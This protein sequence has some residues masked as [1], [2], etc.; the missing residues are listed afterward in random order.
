[1]KLNP[2]RV[3]DWLLSVLDPIITG[4][5]WD[6]VRSI[7]EY[8]V[9]RHSTEALENLDDFVG[10]HPRWKKRFKNYDVFAKNT[11]RRNSEMSLA[12]ANDLEREYERL[13]KKYHLKGWR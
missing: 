2:L 5:R 8:V 13:A 10:K 6:R 7:S 1:M 9:E 11:R 4:L 3:Q 12:L